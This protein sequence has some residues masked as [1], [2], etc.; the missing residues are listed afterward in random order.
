MNIIPAKVKELVESEGDFAHEMRVGYEYKNLSLGVPTNVDVVANLAPLKHGGTY[1]DPQT[2]KDRQFD[3]RFQIRHGAGHHSQRRDCILLAVECKNLHP[4]SP[5]AICGMERSH[6]EANHMFIE[7]KCDKPPVTRIVEN[8]SSLYP[9]HQFVGKSLVRFKKDQRGDLQ[10]ETQGDIYDRWSQAVTSAKEMAKEA[11]SFAEERKCDVYYSFVMPVV[12]V[13]NGLLWKVA[14][15]NGCK[16]EEEPIQV[17][18]CEFFVSPRL[19]LQPQKHALLVITHI[20]FVTMNGW[21]KLLKSFLKDEIKWDTV[22]RITSSV[23][24]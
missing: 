6:E 13:P 14:Y 5:L 10:T 18:D 17:D 3:Y 11:G 8:L 19:Y 24:E 15:S 4:S 7:S 9:P 23:V 2:G 21:I 12:V 22:F 20:H 1:V 16:I